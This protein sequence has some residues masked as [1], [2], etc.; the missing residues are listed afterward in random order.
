MDAL[1]SKLDSQVEATLLTLFPAADKTLAVND[2]Q[3][4]AQEFANQ[5]NIVNRQ[6]AELKAQ[7]DELPNIDNS[8]Q[9]IVREINEL[10]KDIQLK[11]D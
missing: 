1:F 8:P 11:D 6:L 3:H 2:A 9:A 7:I 10:C 5:V 4:R